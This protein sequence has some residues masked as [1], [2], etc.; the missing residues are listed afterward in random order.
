MRAKGINY[1]ENTRRATYIQQ[2]YAIRNPKKFKGYEKTVG[3]LQH[4]MVQ[5]L[6]LKK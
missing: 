5:G 3:V 1:F 4:L 2:Q 6:P